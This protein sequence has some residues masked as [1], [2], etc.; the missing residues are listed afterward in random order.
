MMT[1][2]KDKQ[3]I[4]PVKIAPVLFS[5]WAL[6]AIKAAVQLDVCSTI[7][8]GK[9]TA[10]EIA[11][12]LKTS[13]RGTEALLDALVG[14]EI[15]DKQNG[16]YKLN[17]MSSLYL[18]PDS[19]LFMGSFIC[20]TEQMHS[21]W[22][23]LTD[24]VKTG[25]PC[26]QVNQDAEAEKFFPKLAAGIFPL[27]YANAQNLADKLEIN[28]LPQG[29]K[30][31]DVAAGSAVWSIP[32]AACNKGVKVDVLDFPAVL[33]VTK[34]FTTRFKV[35]EQYTQIAGNW[36][37]VKISPEH[38]DVVI[39]G[40]ILHSEG[41]EL[42]IRLIAECYKA[43]KPGGRLVIA[44][45]MPNDERTAPI[46]PLLFAINMFLATETGCVFS[47]NELKTIL[48]EQGFKDAERL[49]LPYWEKQSP[50]IVARK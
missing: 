20:S 21:G 50:I 37:D 11:S 15:L 4:P 46:Q 36:R 40:H 44:E 33:E 26:R 48:S 32:M 17:D 6:E 7:K 10:E 9:S 30:V 1:I 18:L 47:E 38:Y 23:S 13:L 8:A 24:A 42:S 45:F 2:V 28:K 22:A 5:T 49:E 41:K 31:L 12:S 16:R 25:K 14:M 39:L 35:A 34:D 19:P 29:A 43:L 27:N 3:A